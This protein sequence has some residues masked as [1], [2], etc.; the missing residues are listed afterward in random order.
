MLLPKCQFDEERWP[1]AFFGW[2]FLDL[3]NRSGESLDDFTRAGG[4]PAPSLP[5]FYSIASSPIPGQENVA[6]TIKVPSYELFKSKREGVCSRHLL[7]RDQIDFRF[8]LFHHT[9]IAA[10]RFKSPSGPSLWLT[11]NRGGL[12]FAGFWKK[13]G[14]KGLPG[15]IGF[16]LGNAIKRQISYMKRSG[17]F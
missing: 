7:R 14:I 6:L 15:R 13:D 17:F 1:N 16:S 9:P 10:S 5:R 12:P 11:P 4:S 8:E 2:D 3:Y